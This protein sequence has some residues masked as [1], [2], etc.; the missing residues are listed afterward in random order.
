MECAFASAVLACVTEFAVAFAA[1]WAAAIAGAL[2]YWQYLES[3]RRS[4][5][6]AWLGTI[7]TDGER[8]DES[9]V[10]VGPSRVRDRLQVEMPGAGGAQR[11]G[12][13]AGG[14]CGPGCP[15]EDGH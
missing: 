2:E 10:Q 3:W 13:G 5:V 1:R 12:D 4:M 8:G 7:R 11:Q 9:L 6:S 15:V 14:G